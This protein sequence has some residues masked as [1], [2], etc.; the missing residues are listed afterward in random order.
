MTKPWAYLIEGDRHE[1]GAER[2][3]SGDPDSYFKMV[4]MKLRTR[5]HLGQ[6]RGEQWKIII[7]GVAAHR[8]HMYLA[9]PRSQ[10]GILVRKFDPNFITSSLEFLSDDTIIRKTKRPTGDYTSTKWSISVW[11]RPR[12]NNSLTPNSKLVISRVDY[13]KHPYS[14]DSAPYPDVLVKQLGLEGVFND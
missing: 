7:Q 6:L 3:G 9:T 14:G 11:S 12:L 1:R 4:R 2:R 10:G 8:E 5:R 13:T